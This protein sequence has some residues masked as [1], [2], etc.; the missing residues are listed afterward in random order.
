MRSGGKCIRCIWLGKPRP[1]KAEHLHHVFPKQK[2]YW[3][4]LTKLA[5]NLVGLCTDCHWGHEFSPN[6]AHRLP[7]MALPQ[8]VFELAARTSQ[9]AVD[10]LLT[11]YPEET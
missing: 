1:R 3:P 6:H 7:L 11:T 5:D 9:R 8:C 10:Y 4:R 2:A